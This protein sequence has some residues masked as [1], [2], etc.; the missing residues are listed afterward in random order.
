M[1]KYILLLISFIIMIISFINGWFRDSLFNSLFI[2]SLLIDLVI[3]VSY[4]I[5]FIFSIIRIVKKKELINLITLGILIATVILVI[6]FPFRIYKTKIEFK[7]YEKEHVQ[8]INMIKNNELK[9][10][11][12]GNIELPNKYKKFSSSGEVYLYQNENENLVVGF[13]IF[14]GMHSSTTT[15]LIYTT[16]GEEL[17][18]NNKIWSTNPIKNIIKLEDNWFYVITNH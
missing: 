17:I 1:K 6:F 5:C 8:I 3:L 11:G 14:R 18:K 9:D 2:F 15:E 12:I 10:D 13:W 4:I 7:I 16:G